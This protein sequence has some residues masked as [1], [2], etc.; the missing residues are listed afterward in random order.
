MNETLW[1][2]ALRAADA[3]GL[4]PRERASLTPREVAVAAAERGDDRLALL[5]DGWYYPAS[6]GRARGAL[7][8][9]QAASI[10]SS[11][12][13]QAAMANVEHRHADPI[14][15]NIDRAPQRFLSC[16]LCGRALAPSR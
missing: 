8:E 5:V 12:E 16:D 11:L 13:A 9:E 7:T 14:A 4:I 3:R 1:M 10:V 15:Q 6:Y 2:R